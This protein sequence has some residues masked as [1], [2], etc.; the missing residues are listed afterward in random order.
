MLLRR[1]DTYVVVRGS[2]RL[3]RDD[4]VLFLA[5]DPALRE[6]EVRGELV[7]EPALS[8]C[9]VERGAEPA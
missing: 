4:V 1:Y 2:T 8:V 3:R 9:D 5:D 6:L 7:R